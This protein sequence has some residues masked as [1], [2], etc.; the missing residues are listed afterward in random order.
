MDTGHREH[1]ERQNAILDRVLRILTNDDRVLGIVT[2]G[3]TVRGER[4]AFSDIDI[5]CYLRDEARSGREE[6]YDQVGAVAP[7]LCRLWIYDLNALYLFENGVRLDLD[8]YRPSD[9]QESRWYLRSNTQ[10]LHDPDGALAEQLP[11]HDEAEAPSHPH[12]KSCS[13]SA[14]ARSASSAWPSPARPRRRRRGPPA[15]RRGG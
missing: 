7:L 1:V 2:I 14:I 4:D 6:L 5:A 8:F 11:L 13:R 9:M 3:S 10:T 12:A 15:E